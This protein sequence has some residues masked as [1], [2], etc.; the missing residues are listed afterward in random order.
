MKSQVKSQMKS[1][2]I[3]IFLPSSQIKF[4]IQCEIQCEVLTSLPQIQ[5]SQNLDEM[6]KFQ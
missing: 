6:L 5:S 2:E 3:L 1:R 4:E